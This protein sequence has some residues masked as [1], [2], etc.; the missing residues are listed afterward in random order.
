MTAHMHANELTEQK[1]RQME[2]DVSS[3]Y[4]IQ[5]RTHTS[6][7]T[8]TPTLG[9]R[10]SAHTHKHTLIVSKTNVANF[11]RKPLKWNG[12]TKIYNKKH[13]KLNG[14][15][16]IIVF[17]AVDHRRH[18]LLTLQ[19]CALPVTIYLPNSRAYKLCFGSRSRWLFQVCTVYVCVIV[20]AGSGRYVC[21]CRYAVRATD[22]A[23]DAMLLT[24][25]ASECDDSSP[26]NFIWAI[27]PMRPSRY[28]PS[29]CTFRS[30]HT[31]R[32]PFHYFAC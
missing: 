7:S 11:T 2:V 20:C 10:P 25:N 18:Y 16:I 26:Y 6:T 29:S 27:E 9:N 5:A 15:F 24:A 13:R 3:E 32:L 22:E 14:E 4:T 30:P 12:F 28:M 8:P 1:T 23:C 19:M 31:I 21:V 17:V